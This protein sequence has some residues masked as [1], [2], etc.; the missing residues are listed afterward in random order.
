MKIKKLE[1]TTEDSNPRIPLNVY[2][3]QKNELMFDS[4][5]ND[6][7][8]IKYFAIPKSKNHRKWKEDLDEHRY[9]DQLTFTPNHQL[10]I[11]VDFWTK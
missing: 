10:T 11:N 5:T 7:T 4:N 1:F 6:N 2:N 3:D 9:D 8:T